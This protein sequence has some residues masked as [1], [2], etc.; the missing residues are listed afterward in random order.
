MGSA[1]PGFKLCVYAY[2]NYTHR[3]LSVFTLKTKT[4]II[5]YELKTWWEPPAYG[6]VSVV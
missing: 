1:Q 2:M 5:T 4:I 6:Q 3:A